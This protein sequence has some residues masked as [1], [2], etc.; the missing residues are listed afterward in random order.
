MLPFGTCIAKETWPLDKLAFSFTFLQW[1][2]ALPFLLLLFD[3][4]F[5]FHSADLFS[6]NSFSLS[7]S[8]I[9]SLH[10]S[11]VGTLSF[12]ITRVFFFFLFS[13]VG[14]SKISAKVGG[15]RQ[16]VTRGCCGVIDWVAGLPSITMIAALSL[17]PLFSCY[18]NW[19]VEGSLSCVVLWIYKS[20]SLAEVNSS[21]FN[22]SF[23]DPSTG[24]SEGIKRS[25]NIALGLK[26]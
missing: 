25:F 21:Q 19:E 23:A 16:V 11:D 8:A 12:T 6:F 14:V 24:D 9:F 18:S 7:L 22:G 5:F 17:V 2:A 15:I 10:S 3:F 20:K 4:L 1:T 13:T 26:G